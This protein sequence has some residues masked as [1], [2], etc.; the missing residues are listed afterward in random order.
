MSLRVLLVG[1]HPDDCDIK[2]G[3]LTAMYCDRGH[4]VRILSMTDGSAG[5]HELSGVELADRRRREG[6]AAAAVVGAT[7]E[8][9]DVPDGRLEPTLRERE[10]LIRYVRSYEP[11]LL[12]THRP[13]DYHPDHRYTARL[14]RDAAYMVTVP[15]IC[16]DTPRL[17]DDPVVGY[18][19]DH[20]RKPNPFEPDVAVAVDDVMDD[21]VEMMHRHESQMYEWL[22]Y[23]TGELEAVPDD[24][25]A[26]KEWLREERFAFFTNVRMNVADE[27][28]GALAERYGE[29]RASSVRYAEAIEA[30]EYGASLTNDRRAELFPF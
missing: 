2:A 29:D 8:M 27:Y 16:P 7:F 26:R 6:E 12:V 24:E 18:F 9:F 19:H 21:K 13:N 11:D 5:H 17:E 30:S 20:F 3:G 14:V 15:S 25:E 10:R 4:D 23:N 1:A 22:P 28:R